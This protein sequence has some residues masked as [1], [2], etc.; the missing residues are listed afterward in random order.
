MWQYGRRTGLTHALEVDIE[1]TR[2]LYEA[3]VVVLM[4][5]DEVAYLSPEFGV[6]RLGTIELVGE[7][8][9]ETVAVYRR[10]FE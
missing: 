10:R 3:R 2:V 7:G 9:K 6:F 8:S 4:G 5:L 1:A